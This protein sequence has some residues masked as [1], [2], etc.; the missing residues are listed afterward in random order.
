MIKLWLRRGEK[1]SKNVRGIFVYTHLSYGVYV[2]MKEMENVFLEEC[3]TFRGVIY[4]SRSYIRRLNI[5]TVET[6]E[7]FTQ[8]IRNVCMC[9]LN[10]H[11]FFLS[12]GLTPKFFNP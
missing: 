8:F 11:K 5:L 6:F 3:T 4:R 1:V 7:G 9:C 2:E 10:T 12:Y